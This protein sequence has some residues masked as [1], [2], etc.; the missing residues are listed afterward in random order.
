[1]AMK[2]GNTGLKALYSLAQG[3]SPGNGTE[4]REIRGLKRLSSELASGV[5]HRWRQSWWR[6]PDVRRCANASGQA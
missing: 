5:H 6:T 1:M 3:R 4:R 2:A